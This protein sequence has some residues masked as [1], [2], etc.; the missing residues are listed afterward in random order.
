MLKLATGTVEVEADAPIGGHY[1]MPRKLRLRRELRQGTTYPACS[2]A[3]PCHTCQLAIAG[4]IA[5]GYL[6]QAGEQR[7]TALCGAMEGG[8]V[9]A[10]QQ[11]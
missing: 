11:V 4:D 8:V 6:C 9:H 10:A 1:T 5:D 7:L 2:V 3:K